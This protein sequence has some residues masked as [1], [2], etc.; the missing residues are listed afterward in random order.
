MRLRID[1]SRAGRIL[2]DGW[3]ITGVSL[4]LLL[5]LEGGYRMQAAVRR[6]IASARSGALPAHPYAKDTWYAQFAAEETAA[7]ENLTWRPYVYYRK[8]PFRGTFVNV[9]SLGHRRTVQMAW[10]GS[11]HRDVFMFG[12]S[13]MWGTG[14]RDSMTIPSCVAR[15]LAAEGIRDVA[16]ANFGET[17]WVFSQE[18]LELAL[19]LRA[20]ARPAIVV[21]Y[22]GIN[23][24]GSTVQNGQAGIPDNDVHRVRDF[25]FGQLVFTWVTDAA[26]E[27]RIFSRLALAAADRMQLL[28]RLRSRV[29]RLPEAPD[30][31]LAEDL[32]RTYAGTIELVEALARHYGFV[33]FY[34][35]QPTFQLTPRPLSPFERTLLQGGEQGDLGRKLV[36]LHGRLIAA[37][38]RAMSTEVPDRSLNLGM[39]FASDTAT[40]FLD[41]IGHTTEAASA[42]IAA[43]IGRRLRP[44]LAR[45]Q[46]TRA[47]EP[48][49]ASR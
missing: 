15:G 14:S 7:I 34:V 49:T 11:T 46:P 32:R 1:L 4:A 8:R 42:T 31:S 16:I 23:D 30:D 44:Y 35:L 38:A 13:T 17:G 6:A 29:L 24:V 5:A 9:D 40:V 36:E 2:R 45:S 12:G 28:Q 43:E 27:G 48:G 41:N 39:L 22:D 26:T 47:G 37:I 33:A 19:Q 3:L 20:G 10:L 18:V 25:E 21:F